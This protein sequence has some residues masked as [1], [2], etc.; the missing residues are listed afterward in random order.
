M[1]SGLELIGHFG[2]RPV[3]LGTG[4]VLGAV[5]VGADYR[6][7]LGECDSYQAMGTTCLNK[8]MGKIRCHPQVK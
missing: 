5:R 7:L 3:S 8:A 6:L 2:Q 4:A 1:L